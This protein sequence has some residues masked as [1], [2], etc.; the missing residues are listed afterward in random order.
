MPFLKKIENQSGIIGIWK[1]SETSTDLLPGATLS[2][3]EKAAF[4]SVKIEK[5]K[6]EFLAVRALLKKLAGENAEIIY[7]E[8]GR[9]RLKYS[10]KNISISHSAEFAAVFI[11]D[12]NVGIDVEN[13]NR[14]VAS[15]AKRF[16]SADELTHA[17]NSADKQKMQTI[18]WSAKEAIFKCTS[19]T[20]IQF[21]RQIHIQSFV[22]KNEGKF[23]GDFQTSHQKFNYKLAYFTIE[24]NVIVYCVEV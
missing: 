5:R 10:G 12:K 8:S 13:T 16:L 15:A 4:E 17:E 7:E 6:K 23:L 1:L 3:A 14:N 22:L 11:S 24:N 18:Y 9:P 19:Q 21:N 20:N 2:D